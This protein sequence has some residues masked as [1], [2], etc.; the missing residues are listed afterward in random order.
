ME[1]VR[2]KWLKS[3]KGAPFTGIG[4]LEADILAIIWERQQ[5]TVRDVYETLREQRQIAYTTVMTVMNNLVKKELLT[6]DRTSIAYVYTPA[7]PGN[8]VASTILDSVVARLFR[9]RSNIALSHLLGLKRDLDP[10]QAEQL[11]EYAETHFAARLRRYDPGAAP[12]AATARYMLCGAL[13]P[14][15][16]SPLASVVRVATHRPVRKA[17]TSG[18]SVSTRQLR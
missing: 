14:S 1:H 17:A 15:S 4:S 10:R 18:S 2:P 6:Q 5:A 11:R 12:S 9:G 8:E 3:T 7:I 16:S 13:T